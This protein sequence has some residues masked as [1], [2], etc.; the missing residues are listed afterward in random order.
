MSEKLTEEEW[1]EYSPYCPICDS[2]GEDGCC[3]AT[4][5]QQHPNGHYCGG[6]LNDLKFGYKMYHKLMKLVYEDE[7]YKEQIDVIW[8]EM[9]DKMYKVKDLDS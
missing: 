4:S 5:C 1:E 3:P 7:K 6:Y 2:C 9:Y 8:D